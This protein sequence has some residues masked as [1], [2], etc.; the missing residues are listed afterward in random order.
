MTKIMRTR[1]IPMYLLELFIQIL[2]NYAT[3]KVITIVNYVPD[4]DNNVFCLDIAI[5]WL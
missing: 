2:L 3:E 5:I 4:Y 1:A